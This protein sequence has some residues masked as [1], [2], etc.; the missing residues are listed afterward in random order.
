MLDVRSKRCEEEHCMKHPS[1]GFKGKRPARCKLH[2]VR[3]FVVVVVIVVSV[4]DGV[5]G[6]TVE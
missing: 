2:R 6:G 5:G 4:Y 3:F 1:F